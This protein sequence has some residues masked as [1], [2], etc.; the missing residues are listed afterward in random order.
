MA[1]G[2]EN[3]L[4]K[5]TLAMAWAAQLRVSEYTSK[6]VVDIRSGDDH[7]LQ[8]HNILIQD[9]GLM[10]IFSSDKT[11]KQ[12]KERFIQ[13][14]KIPITG[15][16]ELM[17]QYQK[18]RVKNSPVYFCH[19]D[20][21]NLTPNNIANWIELAT[22]NTDWKGLKITSHCYR[23]GGTSYLYRSRSDIPN[24][25]RSGR[26][27]STDSASVE[28]YLKPGLYSTP[29]QTIRDT[30]PQ[31][32]HQLSAA[33]AIYLR[34]CITT[35]GGTE[36]PFNK[37]LTDISLPQLQRSN[38]PTKNALKTTKGRQTAA[39]A[40]KF[41]QKCGQRKLVRQKKQPGEQ[42]MPSN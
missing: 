42:L 18:I 35:P 21:T 15:Y 23:I 14:N 31:Y 10:V 29:P 1:L 6:L 17:L 36:H 3:I 33:R 37:V 9:D 24:L 20:G 7:N 32:K 25:Q 39:L 16:K 13:W 2:Y 11:S 5:A 41:M 8:S 34:D 27:S 12:R 38:Y 30:L 19:A 4:A 26:W 40:S 22:L 28:H